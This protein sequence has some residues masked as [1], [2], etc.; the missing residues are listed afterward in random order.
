[1]NTREIARI[2]AI[3][4]AYWL[5]HNT[6]R[7]SHG[8]GFHVDIKNRSL[9]RNEYKEDELLD[10]WIDNVYLSKKQNN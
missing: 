10:Y 9:D 1:M 8:Y 3:E 7:H 4:F 5:R 2:I 6:I